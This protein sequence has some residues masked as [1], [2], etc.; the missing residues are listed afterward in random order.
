[1]TPAHNKTLV[2]RLFED[3]IPTGDP[4]GWKPGFAPA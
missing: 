2:R 4:A 1:M 3:V